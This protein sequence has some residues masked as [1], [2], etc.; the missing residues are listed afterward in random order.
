MKKILL[1]L[2]VVQSSLSYGQI[3][4][5]NF[6]D[7]VENNTF[8][9]GT[10]FTSS[11]M[12]GEWTINGD[13]TG[14]PFDPFGYAFQDET[15]AP[16]VLDITGNNAIFVR[17]KA[18]NLGTSLRMDVKDA[19]GFV[20]TVPGV[21]RTLVNDYT[22]FEF[23]YAGNLTD[24]GFGGTACETGPCSVDGTRIVELNFFVN[25]GIGSWAGTVKIDFLS[26]GSI[27]AVGP[28][29]DVF[30]D[31]FDDVVSF[32]Y[33]SALEG[34]TNVIE[35][36]Q[37]NIVGDGTNP[38][39]NNVN[40]LFYN[41]ST[42]DTT[43]VS[44][45]D[46]NDKL[47][48]RMRTDV[49]G[50]TVRVDI[51]DINGFASTAGSI[52]K[53][54][55]DEWTTYEYNYAGSYQDLAFGG[56]GCEVGPCDLD[57]DRIENMIIFINPGVEGFVGQVE[58]DY[59]SVGTPLEAVDPSANTLEYGD[60]FSQDF[61]QVNTVGA[62]DIG[63]EN[64]ELT[65]T[66]AGVDGPF[67]AL[68]VSTHDQGDNI[69]VDAT[70]NNK[71]FVKVKSNTPNTLLRVDL[72]DTS[73]FVT[74]QPSFTRL[75][76]EDYSVLE[77][78]FSAA[79]IDAGFGGTGCEVGPC[80]LNAEAINTILLYPNPVDGGFEGDITI[81]YIS[82]GAPMGED[83]PKFDDHFDDENRDNWSDAG[84]FTVSETGTELTIE[85]DGTAGPF[86]AFEYSPLDASGNPVI[87]DLTSN[88]K[89]YLK[90]KSSVAA[91]LRIDLVD[92]GGF[93]TT[94]P[95][96]IRSMTEEYSILEFDYTGTYNDGGY[97]GT[98]CS[99]GPCPVDGESVVNFL[100]YIDPNNGGYAGT[101][102]IDWFS[103]L[104]P[105]EPIIDTGGPL[106]VDDYADEFEGD[107]ANVSGQDGIVV[108]GDGSI[109]K[110]TGDGTSGAFAPFS[111]GIVENGDSI[112]VNAEANDNKLFIRARSTVDQTALRIDLVDNMNLHTSN[113]GVVNTVGT[114]YSVIEY[115]FAGNY[116]DGGFGGTGCDAGP[117][118]VDAKRIGG[119]NFYLKPGEGAFDGEFD[120]DWIS[121]GEPLLVNVVD[122][123]LAESGKLYPNPTNGE[124]YLELATK[125]SGR[126]NATIT[127]LQGRVLSTF[128][129]GNAI[130]GNNSSRISIENL[131]SGMYI[132]G[133]T[134][135]GKPA[136][137]QKIVKL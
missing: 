37:W 27:P 69:I 51:Q 92:E 103:I 6:D 137:N 100:V 78:D 132:L 120:L 83:V 52:T 88:N 134:I 28:M 71:V 124:L 29:S 26:V 45:A 107:L 43:D 111:Y 102:T 18:S 58:I 68:A 61:G 130:N 9:A 113:P 122:I 101:T 75:L 95:A 22:V 94:E 125:V 110:I 133:V 44:L 20:S 3:F 66:G 89:L 90:V 123:D 106:G 8:Y 12:D 117:C 21:V 64:S 114:E 82:F 39:W 60:H 118:Q 31:Q 63:I 104:E 30:Q 15:G 84:G 79:Y 36:G 91:P 127:D 128:N 62:F 109:L 40:M 10:G 33:M 16:L 34:Y 49:P 87:I 76:E 129:L 14:G 67:T 25:P 85:G 97:G 13:G 17:A 55:S 115:N 96:T 59:I 54:I 98:S 24:G 136:Y 126:L 4:I 46:G 86:T 23:N 105:L 65:I 72:V 131:A 74:T 48:F 1:I 11:E 135:D 80:P 99:M 35:N 77:F 19:D 93:A 112:I 42:L 32:N 47:Y 56:T 5:D 41:T 57:A 108:S 119:I 2:L 7:G 53:L 116:T 73:G 38:M 121:F 50:T 70:N 81:D